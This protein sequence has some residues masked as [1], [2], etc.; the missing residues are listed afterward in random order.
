MT[1][2]MPN[3]LTF[4]A[5]SVALMAMGPANQPAPMQFAL[6][7]PANGEIRLGALWPKGGNG[8]DG[9]YVEVGNLPNDDYL[10]EHESIPGLFY[11]HCDAD[12]DEDDPRDTAKAR[13]A[14]NLD[15]AT[16]DMFG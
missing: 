1:Q 13:F 2:V 11:H 4:E 16:K 6:M 12:L 14:G 5:L 3:M 9:W 7:N 10:D 15:C 8:G